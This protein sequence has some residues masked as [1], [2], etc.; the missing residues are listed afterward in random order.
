[1][2]KKIE[3]Q[4]AQR[5]R[6]RGE[7]HVATERLGKSVNT[8]HAC[9]NELIAW[10]TMVTGRW[11]ET[12]AKKRTDTQKVSEIERETVRENLRVSGKYDS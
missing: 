1:M 12:Q 2:A 11:T 4:K 5:G 7:G 6:A 10:P 8:C 3:L 9:P